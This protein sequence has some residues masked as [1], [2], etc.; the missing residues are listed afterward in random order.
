[1]SDLREKLESILTEIKSGKLDWKEGR[2]IAIEDVRNE[3]EKLKK[4]YDAIVERGDD[5]P[6]KSGAV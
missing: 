3:L 2:K 6:N 4:E 5:H 1:M